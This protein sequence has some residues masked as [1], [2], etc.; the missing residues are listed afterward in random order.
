[1]VTGPWRTPAG[2]AHAAGPKAAPD[3]VSA[4]L[5]V[6]IGGIA[7][8]ITRRVAAGE[9]SDRGDA[10]STY[11][12]DPARIQ[13]L[14]AGAP[15]PETPAALEHARRERS[16]L[17]AIAA[18]ELPLPVAFARWGLDD[19]ERR[20]LLALLAAA[21][22][23]RA[24]RL[25]AVLSGDPSA[26]AVTVEACAALLEPGEAGVARAA[27]RL[28]AGAPLLGLGLVQLARPEAPLARRPVV[29]AARLVELALG[30]RELDPACG[31]VIVAPSPLVPR[32]LDEVRRAVRALCE[33]RARR[34]VGAIAA[35]HDGP[36]VLAALLAEVGRP[37]LALPAAALADRHALGAVARE[38]LLL[39]AVLAVELDD[40]G[41]LAAGARIDEI[42]AAVPTVLVYTAASRTPRV[43]TPIAPIALP[44]ATPDDLQA[45]LRDRLG[46][47][48]PGVIPD[49]PLALGRAL[50]QLDLDPDRVIEAVAIQAMPVP[51]RDALL[52]GGDVRPDATSIIDAVVR[53]WTAAP[54]PRRLRVLLTG[55]KGSGRTRICAAIGRRLGLPAVTAELFR[56]GPAD[57]GSAVEA[58]AAIAMIRDPN[59]EELKV[60]ATNMWWTRVRGLWVVTTSILRPELASSFDL[61][62][63]IPSA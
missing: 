51:P 2:V 23:P 24:G 44:P 12:Y 18:S 8:A 52:R 59:G 62:L 27:A 21:L 28:A 15:P 35:H 38:A 39:D 45:C 31:A 54:L 33:P 5:E 30:A 4:I 47:A 48:V 25:L 63:K 58:G 57:L 1:M 9:I 7:L 37:L 36:G 16:L 55:P 20:I 34:A 53:A 42:A 29:L 49:H 11:F 17:G 60:L 46:V 50:R 3:L 61:H 43:T 41:A 14:V 56:P 22:S 13:Q 26:P 19:D 10:A 6:A 32:A 40:A